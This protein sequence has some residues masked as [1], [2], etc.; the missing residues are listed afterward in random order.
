MA[1]NNKNNLFYK[2]YSNDI[3]SY[4]DSGYVCDNANNEQGT[5][6]IINDNAGQIVDS[7]GNP[8]ASIMLARAEVKVM[9]LEVLLMVVVLLNIQTTQ[10]SYNHIQHIFYKELILALLMKQHS[11][12]FLKNL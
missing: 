2:L 9:M 11:I 5:T 1:S 7:K 6:F 12:K 8:L 10:K 4:V 3:Q